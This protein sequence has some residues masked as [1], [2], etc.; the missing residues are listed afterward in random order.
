[1]ENKRTIFLSIL[2]AVALILAGP[3]ITKAQ[4]VPTDIP[5][6]KLKFATFTAPTG[7]LG[8]NIVWFLKEI[9]RRT[10]GKVQF[11]QFWQQSLLKD[12]D[13]VAGCGAGTADMVQARSTPTVSENPCW[14]TLD[15]PGQGTDSWAII[16]AC[17]KMYQK[18]PCIKAEFDKL[19]VV[20]TYGYCSGNMFFE[21]RRP[22][23]TL[24]DMKGMRIRCYG[25][26]QSTMLKTV[27]IHPVFMS[28]ADIYEGLSKG[29][30]DGATSV[31]Q[32]TDSLKYYEV[33]R[34][35]ATAKLTAAAAGVTMLI[36]KDRWNK[37]P[38]SLRDIIHQVTLEFN[39]R[40]AKTLIDQETSV[41]Q[42]LE[43]KYGVKVV[44]LG[45]ASQAEL[46]KGI[47]AARENWFKRYE[48]TRPV[49]AEF[50]KYVAE[51]EAEVKAKGYPW[52][53]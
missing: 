48:K 40:Y 12:A 17:W 33:A 53:R 46:L 9:T 38:Q 43:S 32:F 4:T 44:K 3:A 50:Q 22:V 13:V 26:A 23:K 30:I 37:F 7:S 31:W 47:R 24:K 16:W 35:I 18:N 14:S 34:Y 6:M 15:L 41:R 21:T 45:A 8:E 49:W 20:P 29:V 5:A 10:G 52:N 28:L 39:N 1:M 19:N 42:K 36:N 27:G 25:A 2:L 51:Y 11:E